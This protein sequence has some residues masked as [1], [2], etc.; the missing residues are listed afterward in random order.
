MRLL[1]NLGGEL[2]ARVGI[3]EAWQLPLTL[4]ALVTAVS[5]TKYPVRVFADF[6]RVVSKLS[7]W[8]YLSTALIAAV[9]CSSRLA[10]SPFLGVP[11]AIVPDEISIIFQTKTYVTGHFANHVHLLPNFLPLYVNATPT[12]ASIYPVLRSFPM[13]LGLLLG[14]GAFGGIILFM[15]VLTVTI[16]WMVREWINAKYAI[17]AAFVVIMRLGL[18]SLWVNSY[19]GGAFTA[20]GGVFLLGGFKAVR[21]RPNLFNGAV[22]GSGVVI[23]MTTR[24]YE[25][26][27]YAAPFG[28]ALILQCIRSPSGSNLTVESRMGFPLGFRRASLRDARRKIP[29]GFVCRYLS[30][31]SPG[32]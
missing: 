30:A 31:Q 15:I 21:S 1:S 7:D 25:G 17:I 18:F 28:A 19:W 3:F 11:E 13:F 32:S 27:V 6:E 14:I 20:L 9:A 22:V 29:F 24:P 16:Y 10:L 5:I 8:P 4:L 12:Y 23:L 2:V 26:L